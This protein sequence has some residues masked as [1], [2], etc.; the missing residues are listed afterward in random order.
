MS[1]PY[2]LY[3]KEELQPYRRF[4]KILREMKFASNFV[5]NQDAFPFISLPAELRIKVY[6]FHFA[7]SEPIEF[8]A[9]TDTTNHDY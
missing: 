1:I 7:F 5:R 2:L 4:P 8:C 9:E 3:T 6:H